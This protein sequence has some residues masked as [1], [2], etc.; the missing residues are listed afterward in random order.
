[1]KYIHV[2]LP[3]EYFCIKQV[4]CGDTVFIND[5]YKCANEETETIYLQSKNQQVL[6]VSQD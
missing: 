5:S 3:D 4:Q 6:R 1:M 2:N